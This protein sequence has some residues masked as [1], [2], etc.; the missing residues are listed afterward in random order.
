MRNMTDEEKRVMTRFVI[1]YICIPAL[2]LA[3]ATFIIYLAKTGQLS[4]KP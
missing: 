1:I 3:A 2:M 4:G